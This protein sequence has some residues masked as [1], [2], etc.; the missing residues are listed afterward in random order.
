MSSQ[1]RNSSRFSQQ[2]RHFYSDV[3]IQYRGFFVRSTLAIFML[4]A[5]LVVPYLLAENAQLAVVFIALPLVAFGF[6]YVTK[7]SG[8]GMVVVLIAA[9]FVNFEIGTGTGS[10]LNAGMLALVGM[11]GLWVLKIVGG[12]AEIRII[13]SETFIPLLLFVVF[14]F[15]SFLAGQIAWYTFAEETSIAAQAGG[16]GVFILS[17][18]AYWLVGNQ[19]KDSFWLKAGLAILFIGATT[20][21]LSRILPGASGEFFGD[22]IPRGASGSMLFL[23]SG[24]MA[25]SQAVFNKKMHPMLRIFFLSIP[26]AAFYVA[27]FIL[28]GWVSGYLPLL[29]AMVV[30]LWLAFP[31]QGVVIGL[32]VA[33]V[34]SFQLQSIL[35]QYLFIGDNTYSLGT[36][37]DAWAILG[38]ITSISPLFGLGPANYYNITPL[39]PIRGYAVQFNSHSQYVDLYAQVGI[40]GLVL[41]FWFFWRV[42]RL[43][44]KLYQQ[45]PEQNFEKAYVV[46]V[47]GGIVGT[48]VSAGLG[49]WVIPFVY[50]IGFR[51]FRSSVICWLCMGGLVAIKYMYSKDERELA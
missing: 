17:G 21:Y 30:V 4:V 48:L 46:G 24:C 2:L 10:S 1:L 7:W 26:V 6:N 15:V 5:A 50:N 44:W 33:A 13:D 37:L 36:R 8:V 34:L 11:I 51:G 12:D 32:G 29:A 38:E 25:L 18:F 14:S 3:V 43:G 49:D 41:F 16:L 28:R 9:L 23:W 47:L 40:V 22:L 42:S 31:K 20:Y 45:I 27:F 19:I 35:N 39:F